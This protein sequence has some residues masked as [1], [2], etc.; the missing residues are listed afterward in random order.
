M[1][2]SYNRS[3]RLSHAELHFQLASLPNLMEKLEAVQYSASRAISGTWKGTSREKLY[4]ELGWESLSS[5]RWSRHLTLFYKF[6]NSRTPEYTTD[7]IPPQR[8]SRYP[9]RNQNV[10]GRIRARTEKFQSSFYPHC[11]SEWNKLDPELRFSP[12]VAAFK[13]RILSKIR[14][15]P[16]S[17]FRI[18]D[19][20]TQVR[21]GLSKLNF[22]K[23]KHNFRDTINPMCPSNDGIEDTEHCLLL[24]PSF[25]ESRRDLLADVS[26][27]TIT[28]ICQSFK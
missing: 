7:P 21:V 3:L 25:E 5:R 26:S 11:L 17:V 28:W 13:T 19:Q 10:I 9:L 24:C 4:A 18:R 22:Q 14:P 16:K 15:V 8:Q 12:S 20:L 2:A 23:F 6:I 27:I 1:P